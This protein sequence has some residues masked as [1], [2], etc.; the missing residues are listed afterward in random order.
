M[1]SLHFA[2]A[3]RPGPFKPLLSSSVKCRESY[4]TLAF[5]RVD[6]KTKQ[7]NKVKT[8]GETQRPMATAAKLY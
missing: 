2:E 4:L 5:L 3:K 8:L 7:H 6:G 1:P